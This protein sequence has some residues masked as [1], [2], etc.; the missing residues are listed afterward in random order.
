MYGVL[1]AFEVQ[2][3]NERMKQTISADT[4]FKDFVEHIETAVD[5]VSNQVY[6]T[7]E[8]IVCIAFY[9]V[10]KSGI[11]YDGVKAW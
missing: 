3:K 6:C 9:A 1:E 11:Y 10:D 8:Q 4:L 5:A 7:K 2:G